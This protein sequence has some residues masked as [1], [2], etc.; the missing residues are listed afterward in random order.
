VTATLCLASFDLS[1]HCASGFIMRHIAPRMEP[2]SQLYGP[3]ARR[4]FFGMSAP[5]SDFILATGHGEPDEY[6]AQNEA[7]IWKV[8]SYDKRET[9]GKVIKLVSCQTGKELGPNLVAN[10][11]RCFMGYSDDLIW[12]VNSA[13]Y[14]IP[15]ADPSSKLCFLPIIDGIHVLLD[16]GT[17]Q[18]S[19]DTEKASYLYSME[20]TDS[21]LIRACLQFNHDHA[22]LLGDPNA[23]VTPR[24]QI[25]FPFGPPPLLF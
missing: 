18:E 17:T 5:A 20:Y 23:T 16:G 22:I 15:W 21:E 19:L 25:S 3:L 4:P 14:P 10:G 7:V 12:L 6:T 24:P 2:F 9:E 11:A 1:S 13:F 8:G